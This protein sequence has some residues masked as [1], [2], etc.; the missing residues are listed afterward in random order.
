MR[1]W[2]VTRALLED[3]IRWGFDPKRRRLFVI[4]GSK[5]LRKA[6]D[7]VFDPEHPVR[8]CRNHK[9]GNAVA[10]LLRDERTQ[11]KAG[12]RS[13]ASACAASSNEVLG[14]DARTGDGPPVDGRLVPQDRQTLPEDHGLRP[15]LDPQG[16]TSRTTSPSTECEWPVNSPMLR[17]HHLQLR[18]GQLSRPM[19]G[20]SFVRPLAAWTACL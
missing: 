14:L 9:L 4:D 15:T 1:P 3:L 11:V 13:T 20:C 7:Q 5:A 19:P 6:I 12:A 8:R 2:L 16:L 18:T 10:H 17:C